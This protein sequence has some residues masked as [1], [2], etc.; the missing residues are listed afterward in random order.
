[1]KFPS[2]YGV[3]LPRLPKPL[4][5]GEL[6][7]L[8]DHAGWSLLIVGDANL[9]EQAAA[10]VL[11]EQ[12]RCRAVSFARSRLPGLRLFDCQIERCDLTAAGCES[13]RLRRVELLGCRLAGTDFSQARFEDVLFKD[14]KADGGIFL[15]A[16]FKAARFENCILC[17]A[18]FSGADLS[19]VVFS[20]CD[21]SQA[22]L[23][24]ARLDGADLSTALIAGMQ[25]GSQDLH[26]A[27]IAWEQAVQ[28]VS[29]LGIVVK[30]ENP[31]Q[32]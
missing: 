5:S 19:G 30:E 20:Q 16:D 27:I 9:S 21:L 25:V 4:P 28:V 32:F 14:C 10:D 15:S 17:G 3:Y 26:G 31:D 22:D 18:S 8:E 13:A 12:V 1:M 7:S 29:L 24:G 11:F 2:R 23:R 6:L